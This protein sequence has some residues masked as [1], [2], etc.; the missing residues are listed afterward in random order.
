MDKPISEATELELLHAF[1]SYETPD[2]VC[3]HPAEEHNYSPSGC[4]TTHC[5]HDVDDYGA[6]NCEHGCREYLTADD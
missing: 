5:L 1:A 4:G 3:G 6:P 2:C